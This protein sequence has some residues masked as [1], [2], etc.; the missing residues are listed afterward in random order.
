M[1][2][3]H[4]SRPQPGPRRFA[5]RPAAA[6]A[7]L[8][9]GLAALAQPSP[10]HAQAAAPVAPPAAAAP[11]G[12]VELTLPTVEVVAPAPLLQT[13]VDRDKVPAETTVL[14]SED[15]SRDNIPSA[16]QALN[17]Q[18]PGVHIDQAAGNPFQPSVFYHGFQA[19]PLQGN[20][21]GLAV[22]LNGARFNQPFG[23]TVLWDLIP[24]IAIDRLN[25]VG[26]NPVFGLNAL[27]GAIAIQMKNGFTFKGVEADLSGGSFDK[28]MGE[29]QYGKQVGNVAAYAAARGLHEG[30]WRDTQSSDLINFFG[31]IGWH[32]NRGTVDLDVIAAH[33]RLNEPGTSP[34]EQLNADISAVFTSPNLIVSRYRRLNLTGRY[35]ISD[36]TSLQGNVYYG[37]LLQKVANG[38]VPDF[39]VCANNP[40]FLCQ[41]DAFLTGISGRPIPNFLNGAPY[42]QLDEQS[43]NTNG[44]GAG[45]QVSNR[46]PLFG[47][48]NHLI[49]GLSFDGAQTLFGASV[50][51]GRLIVANS[52]FAGPGIPI[53]QANGTLGPVRVAISNGYYGAYFTDL[54]DITPTLTANI[55]GRFNLA[56]VDLS[57]Q[58]GT[59]LTGDHTYTRFNPGGG[60]TWKIL[61]DLSLYASYAEAN[62]AP[63]PAELSCASPESACNF[64]NFFVGDPDLKQVIAHTIEAGVRA[65]MHPF[66]SA[67]LTSELSFYHSTLS[68][69]ILAVSA[70][71]QGR[72]FFRNVGD[73]LRQ[74]IDLGFRLNDG[75]FSAWLAYSFTDAEFLTGFLD[76]SENNPFANAEGNIL[77]KPGDRLPGIPEHVVKFGAD[78]KVSPA[79][80]VGGSALYASGQFLFGDE[81]NLTPPTS[82]YFVLN[83]HTDYS[84]TK[85]V[86]LFAVIENAFNER[87][88]TFGTFSPTALVQIAQAPGATNPRSLSVAAP[89]G[90]FVGLRVRF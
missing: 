50:Q 42:S 35:D 74:G 11:A 83:L 69:D 36:R 65:R 45:L 12:G 38:G 86:Q 14:N 17:R 22:Y 79:W 84:V 21:Q 82:P 9:F 44:Y 67:T 1:N 2:R 43:T 18:A 53:D 34:V 49:A 68:D 70:P 48:D 7:V 78:Y 87:Y 20:A 60:L 75:P 26:A 3:D 31:D 8:L 88:F 29:V 62:R 85:N 46:S 80:T 13:G 19:S 59:A 41:D 58:L 37:Y 15:I 28:Y 5:Y 6:C 32:G 39:S 10:A 55:T 54:F 71:V 56:R 61:P 47:H 72:V 51:A 73:T 57:D 52:Q 81:A 30:G 64:A 90:A 24:D 76:P 33:T 16:P 77:V 4:A 27:G 63:T 25:L 66:G 89:I 40:G 23:D